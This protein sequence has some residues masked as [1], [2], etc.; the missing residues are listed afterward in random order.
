MGVVTK[1]LIPPQGIVETS[2]YKRVQEAVNYT[3]SVRYPSVIRGPAGLGKTTALFHLNYK[4]DDLVLINAT[5][6]LKHVKQAMLLIAD[7][8]GVHVHG[9]SAYDV[10][11]S[12]IYGVRERANQGRY[13]IIDEAHRLHL[14]TIREIFDLWEDHGLPIILCGNN[15][16]AKKTRTRGSAFDQIST[17]IG[18]EVSLLRSEP[19]DFVLLGI[20]RNVEGK[21]AYDALVNYGMRTSMREVA[22]LLNAARIYAGEH[23]S[24]RLEHIEGAAEYSFG[25][26]KARTMLS[27]D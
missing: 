23:G 2:T 3:L 17:R 16:V 11:N 4:D 6:M 14:N 1:P 5:D 7:G 21:Q 10:Y 25:S 8:L 15:E 20:E 9:R 12:I 18:K 24:I 19:D 22:Q 26:K 27:P 13:L